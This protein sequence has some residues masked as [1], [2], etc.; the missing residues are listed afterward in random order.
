VPRSF[1]CY[2][3]TESPDVTPLGALESG[4][5]AEGRDIGSV[6]VFLPTNEGD[7]VVLTPDDGGFRDAATGSLWTVT[8]LAIEGPLAGTQ[9]ER[10][11]HLD[12]FWFAWSTYRP[13][14][15]LI[16]P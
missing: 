8:G 5:V 12:T 16:E 2:Q 1:F 7:D 10:V 4:S 6:G 11:P 15:T 14:T 13:G 3:P 9:L